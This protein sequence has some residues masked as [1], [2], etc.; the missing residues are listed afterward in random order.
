MDP[1]VQQIIAIKNLCWSHSSHQQAD[2]QKEPE[3]VILRLSRRETFRWG[4]WLAQSANGRRNHEC[5]SRPVGSNLLSVQQVS[6]QFS[7]VKVPA[8]M[9]ASLHAWG[10][11]RRSLLAGRRPNAKSQS[12]TVPAGSRE[13]LQGQFARDD[14]RTTSR[15]AGDGASHAVAA[16]AA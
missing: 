12:T 15:A 16:A 10:V 1:S 2:A 6:V 4:T 5:R 14:A 8:G 7:A 3:W 9:R 11:D 13:K